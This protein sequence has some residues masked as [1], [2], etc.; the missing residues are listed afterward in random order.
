MPTGEAARNPMQMVKNVKQMKDAAMFKEWRS[1][2]GSEQAY[3]GA[4]MYCPTCQ[5][6]TYDIRDRIVHIGHPVL[7]KCSYE[8]EEVVEMVWFAEID[9]LIKPKTLTARVEDWVRWE[10]E[11]RI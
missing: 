7:Y 2:W 9:G 5:Y 3:D 8:P 11:G 6:I 1:R 10:E 4:M